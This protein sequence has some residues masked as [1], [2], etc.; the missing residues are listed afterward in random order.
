MYLKIPKR[1]LHNQEVCGFAL[2]KY[3][4]D[5]TNKQTTGN[6]FSPGNTKCTGR[7]EAVPAHAASGSCEWVFRH[8]SHVNPEF[9]LIKITL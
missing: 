6:Y 4:E 1:D 5:E 2:V 9:D 7:D 3:I 8:R